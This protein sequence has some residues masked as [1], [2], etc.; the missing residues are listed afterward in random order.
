M[1]DLIEVSL[2]SYATYLVDEGHQE[3]ADAWAQRALA[4]RDAYALGFCA[5]HGTGVPEDY[6]RASEFLS[7]AAA[8]NFAHAF[9]CLGILYEV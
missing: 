4:S 1:R 6:E 8:Q 3:E 7:E 9:E 2:H 5:F